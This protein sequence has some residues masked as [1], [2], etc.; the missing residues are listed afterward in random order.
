[1]PPRPQTVTKG[2]WRAIALS[3]LVHACI[4]VAA[5]MGWFVYKHDPP[6][7]TLAIDATVVD[8]RALKGANQLPEVAPEPPSQP[9]PAPA[10]PVP[11]P[12]PEP[13]PP[14]EQGPPKPDPAEV[15]RRLE[16]ERLAAEKL[17]QE[18]Q[19][20]LREQADKEAAE[21]KQREEA[22]KLEAQKQAAAREAAE[23]AAVEKAA[24][25]KRAAEK[26]RAEDA[27]AAK[28]AADEKAR[29]AREAELRRS[30][31]AEERGNALRTSDEAS[32]W[33]AQIVARI[34]RAWIKPPSAQPGISC[35]VSVTQVPG[36]EVTTVRVD[37]CSGGDAALR[38]S[39]EAAVY[40]ASPLPPPPDPRLFERNLLL[41]FEPR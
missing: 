27:A 41:T 38:E 33:H 3:V 37:S 20:Q 23:K 24:A 30:L 18:K 11:E 4:V 28:K 39:V 17:E 7:P 34:Q 32:R 10:E 14:E 36:G 21:L 16:E 22:E 12:E 6:P 1:M 5:V 40:R 35:T 29:L 25:E 26:K 2:G 19:E 13:P 9:E 8:E 15:E 31:E